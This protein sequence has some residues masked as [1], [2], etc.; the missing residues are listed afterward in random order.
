MGIP[1]TT[2]SNSLSTARN[3]STKCILWQYDELMRNPLEGVNAAPKEENVYEWHGNF[4]FPDDHDTYPCMVVHFTLNLT[5]DFPNSTPDIQLLTSF[6]HSHVFGSDI[7]FSLLKAFEYHFYGL[8]TT[9]YW[10]PSRSIRS[11]LEAVYVFLTVDEDRYGKVHK[12][13]IQW[14][15]REARTRSCPGCSHCPDQGWQHVVR[16]PPKRR[17]FVLLPCTKTCPVLH[18]NQSLHQANQKKQR[19]PLHYQ[20]RP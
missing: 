10:N 13:T 20:P 4:Y 19:N 2:S 16:V 12:R 11:L 14:A 18:P 15:Q 6:G 3:F 1:S 17:R 7:C 8:P 9:A 5:Y